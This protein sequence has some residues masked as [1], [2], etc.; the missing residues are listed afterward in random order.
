MAIGND[1]VGPWIVKV[2]FQQVAD[3]IQIGISALGPCAAFN[4]WLTFAQPNFGIARCK[5][6]FLKRDHVDPRHLYVISQS[7]SALLT[8]GTGRAAQMFNI[9]ACNLQKTHFSLPLMA[10]LQLRFKPYQTFILG[11]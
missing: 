11:L 2:F 4:D 7:K 5:I 6:D 10:G 8:F 1:L 9:P 3:D